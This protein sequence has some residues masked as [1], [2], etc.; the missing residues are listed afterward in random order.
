MP[1]GVT[2][3]AETREE[4]MRQATDGFPRF[5]AIDAR[6]IDLTGL[7]QFG[8]QPI[9]RHWAVVVQHEDL[10]E[11]RKLPQDA[12]LFEKCERETRLRYLTLAVDPASL[13]KGVHEEFRCPACDK[14]VVL[15]L[16]APQQ[17]RYPQNTQC[18][19]CKTPLTRQQGRHLT[20]TE[21][22]RDDETRQTTCIFCNASADSKE[23]LVPAW[24]SKRLGIKTFLVQGST[25]GAVRPK[26]QPISFA[27]HRARILCTGCNTHFKHLEDAVIPLL[28]PMARGRTLA[29]NTDTQQ[30]L[31]LWA[32]K[33]AMVL[34]A[35]TDGLQDAVPVHHRHTVRH[36]ATVPD[37][38]WVGLCPWSGDPLLAVSRITPAE[39]IQ[40]PAYKAILTF[41]GI[42]FCVVGFERIPAGHT[43]DGNVPPLHSFAPTRHALIE[44]PGPATVDRT[45]LPFLMSFIPLAPAPTRTS[46][47]IQRRDR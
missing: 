14:T 20:W 47:E 17:T 6:E 37:D 25:G 10:D 38:V 13:V 44:W 8:G 41:A 34:I 26:P 42:G 40:A 45:A 12:D 36:D 15:D 29:I 33:T 7:P 9:P 46:H 21:I 22:P 2:T 4:A 35:A 1:R 16:P 27:S 24:I 30:V 32:A 39:P 18:P 31:A 23:H 43:I 3:I 5:R 28:V 19:H 11:E